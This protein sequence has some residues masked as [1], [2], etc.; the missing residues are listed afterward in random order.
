[1]LAYTA[2]TEWTE[3]LV[4]LGRGADLFIA[5]AYTYERNVRNHLSLKTLEAYLA[6]IA[7]KRLILTHM[8]DDMLSRLDDLGHTAA[9]DGMIIEF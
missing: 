8:S 2:D 1:V 3:T 6:E 4:P 7:P 9:H 5:E